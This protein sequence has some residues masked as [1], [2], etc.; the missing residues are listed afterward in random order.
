MIFAV[1]KKKLVLRDLSVSFG[2]ADRLLGDTPARLPPYIIRKVCRVC[3]FQFRAS[4][5]LLY[6]TSSLYVLK[7]L[8][9]CSCIRHHYS[10][11]IHIRLKW[12]FKFQD[13]LFL[14]HE[15]CFKFLRVINVLVLTPRVCV[16]FFYNFRLVTALSS[17]ESTSNF[18]KVDFVGFL[19]KLRMRCLP[20]T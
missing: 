6:S 15:S 10:K 11:S 8:F 7:K 20:R 14:I 19:V 3:V 18:F 13:C 12:L 5:R 9:P 1:Q 16:Y 4:G 2:G 17:Y